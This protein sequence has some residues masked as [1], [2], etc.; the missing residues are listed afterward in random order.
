MD[1]TD[2]TAHLETAPSYNDDPPCLRCGCKNPKHFYCDDDD[3]I[4]CCS[5][6]PDSHMWAAGHTICQ[7]C[8]ISCIQAYETPFCKMRRH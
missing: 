7:L 3:T 4:V 2:W 6:C 5:E 8:G 1:F